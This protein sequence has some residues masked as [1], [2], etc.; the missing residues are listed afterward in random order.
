MTLLDEIAEKVRNGESLE[1]IGLKP[2]EKRVFLVS[3]YCLGPMRN[4]VIKRIKD[5]IRKAF[6]TGKSF[7]QVMKVISIAVRRIPH[8]GRENTFYKRTH[9]LMDIEEV[10]WKYQDE[11]SES[12][13]E[14]V[15]G[16]N[17]MFRNAWRI[18][19]FEIDHDEYYQG[20]DNWL[21]EQ[22]VILI[23]TGEYVNRPLNNP[24]PRLW[25]EPQ[26][27]GGKNT[28]VYAIQQNRGRIIDLLGPEWQWLKSENYKDHYKGEKV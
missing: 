6:A 11:G 7:S 19:Q 20:R 5:P 21:D 22:K 2:G 23:L 4:F 1:N 15:L 27:Y 9:N 13:V 25:H 3:Q 8:L 12:G 14:S 10:F 16:R 24:L 28:I 26:P 18:Y 17:R